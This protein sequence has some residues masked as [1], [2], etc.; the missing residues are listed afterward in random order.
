M[1]DWKTVKLGNLFDFKNGLNKGVEY[2][3]HGTP[4]INYVDVNKLT[5]LSKGNFKGLVEVTDSEK[6]NCGAKKGDVFFTRTSETLD[7]VGLASVL[8]DEID[9]CVFSGYVLR[10]RPKT[11]ELVPKYCAYSLRTPSIRKEIMRKSS[12][13]T[14]ALTNGRFLSD[15]EFTYPSKGLQKRI[16][17]ILETWDEY[18]E[19]LDQKIEAKKN[20]KKG[21]TQQLL[22]GEKRLPGYTG[23]WNETKLSGLFTERKETRQN[24]LPLLSITSGRKVIYQ[25]ESNKKDTSNTDKSKYKRICPGDIGYNTMRMWQGR[26][27]LSEI[28]GIISPAYTVVTPIDGI[29]DPMYFSYLFRTSRMKYLFFQKSQ[30]IV[31]DTWNCKFKD[32]A[33]VKYQVP[34]YDEQMAI[35]RILALADQEID[36]LENRRDIAAQQKKYL[37]NNLVSGGIHVPG[38]IT[39]ET[40]HA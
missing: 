25:H 12:M 26:S 10:G 27:A 13:T 19:K 34:E 7:E 28:E 15:V 39:K 32:F 36:L 1:N 8:L 29:A 31:S 22:T 18:L 14:R 23:K 20:I 35:A 21:L 11:D 4:I 16:I 6:Q 5:H 3:G 24:H 30:G 17:R 38:A 2:F 33:S 9:D 40:L 37:L